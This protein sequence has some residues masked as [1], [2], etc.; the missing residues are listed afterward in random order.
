MKVS[1]IQKKGASFAGNG[2]RV[3]AE[4]YFNYSIESFNNAASTLGDKPPA[5]WIKTH[6]C[7]VSFLINS[8]TASTYLK[9]SLYY[10]GTSKAMEYIT[11]A[12]TF[13]NKATEDGACVLN[14]K[15]I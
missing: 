7:L 11:T 14:T 4:N 6:N 5:S 3:D 12:Q 2:L 13:A 9:A 15:P 10:S 1:N 8:V